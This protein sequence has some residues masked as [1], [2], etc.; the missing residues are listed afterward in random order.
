MELKEL[1]DLANNGL[2]TDVTLF[3]L[4]VEELSKLTK[5]DLVQYDIFTQPQA[6]DAPVTDQPTDEPVV[7]ESTPTEP[8]TPAEPEVEDEEPVEEE[9][10]VEESTEE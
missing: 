6:W 10:V 7:E 1:Q 5:E 4:S 2:V 9:P 8:I 3:N